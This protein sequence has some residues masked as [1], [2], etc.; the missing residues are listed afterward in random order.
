M[1]DFGLAKLT[2]MAAAAGGE[3]SMSPTMLGTVAGQVMGTAG[4]MAPEQVRGEDV[5]HRADLFAFGCVLYAMVA[6]KPPFAGRNVMQTL[7]LILEEKPAPLV[8]I[9]A[10]LPAELW[11]IVSKTLAKQPGMRYQ[12]AADLVVD[13]RTLASDP[14]FELRVAGG[15]GN[16]RRGRRE[17]SAGAIRA[18][19]YPS[20]SSGGRNCSVVPE[21]GSG[22]RTGARDALRH[23]HRRV[24]HAGERH[25]TLGWRS[26]R[27]GP[28]SPTSSTTSFACVRATRSSPGCCRGRTAPAPRCS[29]PTAGRSLTS[30]AATS[31]SS[32]WTVARRCPSAWRRSAISTPG[33][34]VIAC[35]SSIGTGR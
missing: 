10:D 16:D 33:R 2:E 9:N 12:T 31:R 11:R 30:S 17:G 28:T 8:E 5:D 25:L 19:A 24:L 34:S 27:Q 26:H 18:C 23:P 22:S 32:R 1:L 15:E 7:D 29:R 6:G 14:G 3:L 35:C 21:T 4:Y 13:L 20:D